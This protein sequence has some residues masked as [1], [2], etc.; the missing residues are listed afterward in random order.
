[1]AR[2]SLGGIIA[3]GLSGFVEAFADFAVLSGVVVSFDLFSGA[4]AS[5]SVVLV[6]GG[7]GEIGAEY[8]ETVV[9]VA[10]IAFIKIKHGAKSA[11]G[12]GA[13]GGIDGAAVNAHF[14]RP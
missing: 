5:E 6:E 1:M 9:P 2:G 11:G 12:I 4:A 3:V 8:G 10:E 14:L 13:T 7:G